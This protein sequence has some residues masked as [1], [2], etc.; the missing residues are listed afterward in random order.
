MLP[1]LPIDSYVKVGSSKNCCSK[2]QVIKEEVFILNPNAKNRIYLKYILNSDFRQFVVA[3]LFQAAR[4][5][6]GNY[7]LY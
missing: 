5:N 7:T 6:S 3:F 1:L 2:V 4:R